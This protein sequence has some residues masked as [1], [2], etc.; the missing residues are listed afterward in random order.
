MKLNTNRP[1]PR[2]YEQ[3]IGSAKRASLDDGIRS[4]NGLYSKGPLLVVPVPAARRLSQY[5]LDQCSTFRMNFR[6]I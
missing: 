6:K 4:L 1:V 3:F 2:G 5:E